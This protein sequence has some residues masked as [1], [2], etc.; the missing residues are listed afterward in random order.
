MRVALY[1]RRSTNDD[2]QPESLNVQ[3][4]RLREYAS[5]HDLK[6]VD[7]FAD[8]ASGLSIKGRTEFQRLAEVVRR[9]ANFDDCRTYDIGYHPEMDEGWND[10]VSSFCPV[11]GNVPAC[12]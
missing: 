5:K 11:P 1:L 6:I 10:T 4:E 12:Q 8:S 7:V 3:E 9:G 2:L